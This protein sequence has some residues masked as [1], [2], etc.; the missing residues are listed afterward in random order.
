MLAC[1]EE[2]DLILW[3]FPDFEP[4]MLLEGGRLHPY[5]SPIAG[6]TDRIAA[7]NTRILY[8]AM[9]GQA[10]GLYDSEECAFWFVTKDESAQERLESLFD[11]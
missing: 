11:I 2:L 1:D 8:Q 4:A 3:E 7:G 6:I 5:L 10:V 9:E